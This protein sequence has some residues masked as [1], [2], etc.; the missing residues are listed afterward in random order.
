[1]KELV[2]FIQFGYK[3][4]A[5]SIGPH[6]SGDQARMRRTLTPACGIGRKAYNRAMAFET[7]ERA[8]RE[9]RLAALASVGSAVLLVSLKVFLV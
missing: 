1:M 8:S 2:Y 4:L 7:L 9:K 3:L 6:L 5:P